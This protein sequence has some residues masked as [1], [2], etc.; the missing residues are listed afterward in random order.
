MFGSLG[1]C[2]GSRE[3]VLDD[4]YFILV[5]GYTVHW[6]DAIEVTSWKCS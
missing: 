4:N 6:P 1:D 2:A 5:P 3:S